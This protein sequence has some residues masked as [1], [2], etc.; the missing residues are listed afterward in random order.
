MTH[1]TSVKKLSSFVK[2]NV[3]VILESSSHCREPDCFK[4]LALVFPNADYNYMRDQFKPAF[5]V[6]FVSSRGGAATCSFAKL[7]EAV[8]CYNAEPVNYKDLCHSQKDEL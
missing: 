4:Q 6:T 2:D 8:N 5:E 1:K 7:N 3:A